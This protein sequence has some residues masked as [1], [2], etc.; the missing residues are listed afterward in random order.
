MAFL[1]KGNKI[2]MDVY[3]YGIQLP[4]DVTGTVFDLTDKMRFELKKSKDSETLIS[5]DYLNELDSTSKFRF[6]LELTK[7]EAALISPGNYIYFVKYLKKIDGVDKVQNTIAS[8]LFKVK[9]GN[10]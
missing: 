4:F 8:D 6:F 9:N 2:T 5:R 7:E 3:D 1:A 10:G